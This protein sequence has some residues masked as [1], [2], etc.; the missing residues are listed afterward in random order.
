MSV[1]LSIKG[2]PLEIAQRLRER[3]A[4]NHRSLQREL[5]VIIEEAAVQPPGQA[6]PDERAKAVMHEHAPKA[7]R[8]TAAHARGTKTIDEV[9]AE[10]RRRHPQPVVGA[11]LA[12]DIVRESRDGR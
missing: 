4:R 5:M 12:V 8:D 11:P 3:A 10:I 1:N 9:V 2:V 6:S 7:R